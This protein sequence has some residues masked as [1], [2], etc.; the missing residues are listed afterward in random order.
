MSKSAAVETWVHDRRHIRLLHHAHADHIESIY[1][2]LASLPGNPRG[3]VVRH[4]GPVRTLLV[5]GNSWENR[6]IFIGDETHEQID[7]VLRHS[8]DHRANCV[9]EINTANSY[10]DPPTNWEARL[11]PHLLARG[12]RAGGMRCV[13]CCDQRMLDE[14]VEGCGIDRFLPEQ[15]GDYAAA[16]TRANPNEQ[17]DAQRFAIES[18]PDAI[19]YVGYD[20]RRC[21]CAFGSLF[22]KA[23]IAYLS[24][25]ETRPEHRRCG[26][27]LAGIRRRIA[28]AFNSGCKLVFTVSDYNVASSRNLQRCGFKLAYNYLVVTGDPYPR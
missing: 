25:W 4:I 8:S 13:W 7:G 23:P 20:T 5:A 11:L 1:A 14:E 9:I 2:A 6:A 15:V 27:Q 10:V 22:V 28:D 19:H 24:Y 3:V 18:R 12:C 16:M 21:A 26:F 17:W